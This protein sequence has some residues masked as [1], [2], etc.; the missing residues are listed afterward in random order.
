MVAH[1]FSS[2]KNKTRWLTKGII[3]WIL[4]LPLLPAF[5]ISLL[6]GSLFR[7]LGSLMA[8]SLFWGGAL[9]IRRGL[10]KEIEYNQRKMTKAPRVPRKL[11]GI[12]AVTLGS[13]VCSW[14][15]VGNSLFFALF[16]TALAFI[17]C[18]LNYGLDP[19]KDK[20]GDISD[21][22]GYTSEEILEAVESAEKKIVGIEESICQFNNRE[23]VS[24]LE[25]ITSLARLIVGNLEKDPSDLRKVRKFINVYLEGAEKVTTGYAETMAKTGSEELAP[26]FRNLLTTIEEVFEQQ[27]KKLQKNDI[28]DLDIKMEVLMKRLQHEGVL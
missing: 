6:R 14:F 2:R 25:H 21:G 11:L 28:L 12:V 4:P 9:L 5:F 18:Y 19:R 13:L 27:H 3:L 24:R 7:A 26:Q 16:T 1:R 15:A 10:K 17:S 23:L 8:L 22:F 20:I